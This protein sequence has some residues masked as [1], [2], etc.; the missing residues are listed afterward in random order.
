MNGKKTLRFAASLM[1]VVVALSAATAA[2]AADSST[3]V[4]VTNSDNNPVVTQ[5]MGQRAS[6]MVYLFCGAGAARN[7]TSPAL[8]NCIQFTAN[9]P[10]GEEFTVPPDRYL[11]ITA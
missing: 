7:P 4:K 2:H 9:N 3:P 6:Q 1:A 11:V 8:F 10:A 5:D